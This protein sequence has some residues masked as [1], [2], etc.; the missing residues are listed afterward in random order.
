MEI[1]PMR[2]RPCVSRG[3]PLA[4]RAVPW[5]SVSDPIVR[6]GCRAGGGRARQAGLAGGARARPSGASGRCGCCRLVG[7][8]RAQRL[9]GA[10]G[11]PGRLA[12]SRVVAALAVRLRPDRQRLAGSSDRRGW[13]GFCVERTGNF[14]RR[15]CLE[16]GKWGEKIRDVG[17][18][19]FFFFALFS[20]QS[21]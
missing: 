5:A 14:L 13:R 11:R 1:I 18:V 15:H 21:R 16:R 9:A 17:G 3:W 8:G 12:S 6:Q 4:R 7:D 20:T 19:C 2:G 10:S